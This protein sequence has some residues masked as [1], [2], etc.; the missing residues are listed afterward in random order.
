MHINL[1]C[2]LFVLD[3]ETNDNIR[4]NNIPKIKLLVDHQN[5]IPSIKYDGRNMKETIR[6]FIFNLIGSHIFHLEQVITVDYS[7]EVN[8]VYLAIT[9]IE[10]IKKLSPDY[11]LVDFKV[12]D[13]SL[14][15][16]ANDTYKYKTVEKEQYNNIEYIHQI[17][18]SN[19]DIEKNLLQ[20]LTSYKRLRSNIDNT[21]ILFKFMGN[22][23]TLEDVRMVYELVKDCRVDKSNFRKKIVK[24][25]EKIA[26]Y[27]TTKK[28]YRPSQKYHFKPLKGDIWI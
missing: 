16:L 11:T 13:N 18:I 17:A 7:N 1:T 23:F 22:S 21:D 20:I 25:C 8:V 26:D 15:T 5:T 12:E 14:I 3:S 6:E 27:D 2:S 10:N 28:G 24:Y 4:K 9:N 19:K